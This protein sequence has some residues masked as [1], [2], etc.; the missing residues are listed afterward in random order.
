VRHDSRSGR[1]EAVEAASVSAS[2]EG[3]AVAGAVVAAEAEEVTAQRCPEVRLHDP[4]RVPGC[5]GCGQ[6]AFDCPGHDPAEF[7]RL[8]DEAF[9]S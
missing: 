9:G 6:T 8:L 5:D 4:H 3:S 2:A 1:P 7:D